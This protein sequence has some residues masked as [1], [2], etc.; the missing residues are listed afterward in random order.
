MGK[1]QAYSDELEELIGDT[2]TSC[3]I[4]FERSQR[5]DF[6][7]PDHDV[8]LEVKK[9]HSDRSS[10][11]LSSQDNVILIQG[12]KSVKFICHI[13]KLSKHG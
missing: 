11:Q 5:L 10:S 9:Y 2:L 4:R 3:D 1:P 7:L 8:Y 12:A 6:F 13:L